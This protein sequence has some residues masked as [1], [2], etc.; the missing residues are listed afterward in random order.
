V[1][2]AVLADNLNLEVLQLEV[3]VVV[4]QDIIKESKETQLQIVTPLDKDILVVQ[5][6]RDLVLSHLVVVAVVL[7]EWEKLVLNQ[8]V[9]LEQEEDWE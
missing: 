1:V 9:L 2:V 3:L 8:A 6:L 4:D 7:V 5:V